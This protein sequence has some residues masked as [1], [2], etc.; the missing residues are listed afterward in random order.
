VVTAFAVAVSATGGYPDV[1][2]VGLFAF[3]VAVSATGGYPEAKG[4]D[5]IA[6]GCPPR[7]VALL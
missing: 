2:G 7:N 6:G 3:A 1:M 4:L 5:G